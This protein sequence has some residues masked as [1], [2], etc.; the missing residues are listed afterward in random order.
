MPIRDNAIRLTILVTTSIVMTFGLDARSG[1]AIVADQTAVQRR[2][3]APPLPVRNDVPKPGREI[4][5]LRNHQLRPG[6]HEGFYKFSR[7]GY[8][9]YF[10]RIGARIVG[11]WKVVEPAPPVS[12]DREDVYRLVRYAS[13]E[14]WLATRGGTQSGLGGNGPAY[15]NGVQGVQD[16]GNLEVGSRGA[17]FLEGVMASGGPY[18]MPGLPEQYEPMAAGSPPPPVDRELPVRLDAVQPGDEIVALSYQRIRKREFDQFVD[19]TRTRIWPWEEKLGARPIGQWK[20]VYPMTPEGRAPGRFIT[21]ANA[22]YDE[23]V[24]LTR[25]ASRA[26]MEAMSPERAV[27]MGGNGP[28][29]RAWRAA[30]DDQATVTLSTSVELIQGFLY[31]SPPLFLPGLPEQYRRVK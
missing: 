14:H 28:D 31:Q 5:V 2:P 16:R 13:F 18:F 30:L 23:V 9:P 6:G 29:W 11:Q 17:Y 25:F 19:V 3:P 27:Y 1:A 7:D 22:G 20:V 26:H 4:L 12:A 8:W 21:T 15:D 24:T 10:E